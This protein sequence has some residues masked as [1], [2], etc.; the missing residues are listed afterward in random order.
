MPRI[1]I[2]YRRVDSKTITGR[3]YDRLSS[4]FGKRN[5]FK[6]VD[7]LIPGDDFRP[8]IIEAVRKSD[9]L[10]VIIGPHWLTQTDPQ[11]QRRIDN[12]D[13]FVRLEIETGL[14]DPNVG[15]YPLL[16]NGALMPARDDLPESLH[17]LRYRHAI[18]IRE[19]PDFHHDADLLI[20]TLRRKPRRGAGRRILNTLIAAIAVVL[21][22]LVILAINSGGFEGL[23]L[24]ETVL[25]THTASDTAL[26]QP[27]D[28]DPAW[29]VGARLEIAVNTAYLRIRPDMTAD[30]LTDMD[31]LTEGTQVTLFTEMVYDHEARM[32]WC[33]IFDYRHNRLGWI[34]ASQLRWTTATAT[35]SPTLTY[36]PTRRPSAT[37][38]PYYPPPT[39]RPIYPTSSYRATNTPVVPIPTMRPTSIPTNV[40]ACGNYICEAGEETWCFTDCLRKS[41]ECGNYICE[42]GE[43]TWCWTDCPDE[44][45]A[46]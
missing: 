40:A 19:D 13:D 8:T 32:W 43:S 12:P 16:V 26:P 39:P 44:A 42:P 45:Q 10:L 28:P 25:P 5:V 11:G 6:D 23:G 24:N 35:P 37:P 46:D 14:N 15:V 36:T 41:S 38:R 27:T 31:A 1:F 34:A 21:V 30:E 29:H 2:S 22:T 3:L 20:R 33:Q 9:H 17:D 4:T 7:D 18:I